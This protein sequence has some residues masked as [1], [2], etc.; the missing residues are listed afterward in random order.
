[1]TD[2]YSEEARL[3]RT[4]EIEAAYQYERKRGW[5]LTLLTAMALTLSVTT[6]FLTLVFEHPYFRR[7]ETIQSRI[8]TLS[9]SLK[10]AA[11]IIAEIE[12][13]VNQRR[14]LVSELERKARLAEQLR[15]ANKEEVEAISLL[16]REELGRNESRN[17]W[18][19]FVQNAFFMLAGAFVGHFVERWMSRRRKTE[20]GAG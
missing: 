1:M 16:L 19:S 3:Q 7:D 18:S 4:A 2:D 12:R 17:F 6:L 20:I 13:E 14:D 8:E 10:D 15:A 5:Q 11:A 9:G